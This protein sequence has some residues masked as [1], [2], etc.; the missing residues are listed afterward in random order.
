MFVIHVKIFIVYDE[1]VT[2]YPSIIGFFWVLFL[3]CYLFPSVL[4][5]Y[6]QIRPEGDQ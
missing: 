5:C 6:L 1:H 4:L 3:C 2:F